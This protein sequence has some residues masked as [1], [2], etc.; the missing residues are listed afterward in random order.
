ML[1]RSLVLLRPLLINMVQVLAATWTIFGHYVNNSRP[2]H[3]A[4][5]LLDTKYLRSALGQGLL[6]VVFILS[7]WHIVSF[8]FSC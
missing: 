8:F 5:S 2:E 1:R 6:C 4:V 3:S 7:G